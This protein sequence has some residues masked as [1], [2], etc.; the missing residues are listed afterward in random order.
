MGVWVPAAYF[1]CT[2]LR[3]SSPSR[4]GMLNLVNNISDVGVARCGDMSKVRVLRGC[5]Y[6][7]PNIKLQLGIFCT[8]KTGCAFVGP[9]YTETRTKSYTFFRT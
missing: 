4:A 9:F 8:P 6:S 7:I 2:Y 3:V 1:Y 5:V